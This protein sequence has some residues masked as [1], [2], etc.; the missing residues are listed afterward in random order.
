MEEIQKDWWI[1]IYHGE[2]GK[3]IVKLE[4][5]TNSK[6]EAIKIKDFIKKIITT[7]KPS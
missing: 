4:I 3:E 7:N 5:L 6:E 2:Y 1:Q